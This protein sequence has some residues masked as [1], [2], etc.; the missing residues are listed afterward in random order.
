MSGGL[1]PLGHDA[2]MQPRGNADELICSG[3]SESLY[4]LPT[5]P[6]ASVICVS[7]P[8][9]GTLAI[10]GRGVI[11]VISGVTPYE[12]HV[13]LSSA[14]QD[15]SGSVAQRSYGRNSIL[16]AVRPLVSD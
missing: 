13:R 6:I 7:V 9:R 2:G 14:R 3:Q 10:S 15:G 5:A 1:R 4:P 16:L 11:G 12:E 8:G